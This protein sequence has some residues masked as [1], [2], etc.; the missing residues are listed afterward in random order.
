MYN[1]KN[2]CDEESCVASNTLNDA[3]ILEEVI[4]SLPFQLKKN[5]KKGSMKSLQ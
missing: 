1:D 5:I 3:S 4:K 2:D